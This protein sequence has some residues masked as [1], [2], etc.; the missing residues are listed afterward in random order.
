MR[1]LQKFPGLGM[2]FGGIPRFGVAIRRN[3]EGLGVQFG[4]IPRFGDGIL[5]KFRGF[6]Q[7]PLHPVFEQQ[8]VDILPL[9]FVCCFVNFER[10]KV[11]CFLSH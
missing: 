1:N 2:Q 3:S 8:R 7:D 9:A 11:S 10:R 6:A 5:G 4:G